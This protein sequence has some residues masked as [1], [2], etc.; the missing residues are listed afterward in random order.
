MTTITTHRPGQYVICG[1]SDQYWQGTCAKTLHGAK[2][3]AGRAYQQAFLGKIEVAQV[4]DGQYCRLAVKH[5]YAA[6]Q[7]A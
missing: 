1:G 3:A 5:G 7:Q 6:W 2:I 4:I